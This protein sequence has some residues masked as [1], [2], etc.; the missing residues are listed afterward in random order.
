[1][2]KTS[3]FSPSQKLRA[4]D[5]QFRY[6]VG[7]GELFKRLN[8][9]TAPLGKE[10]KGGAIDKQLRFVVLIGEL[11]GPDDAL[12]HLRPIDRSPLSAEQQRVWTDLLYLYQQYALQR[13][14]TIS[15]PDQARLRLELGWAG[16]LALHPAGGPDQ[17]GR[18]AL[19]GGA[20]RTVTIV[21]IIFG[22]VL[23]F[24]LAGL[25][26]FVT[27]IFLAWFGKLPSRLAEPSGTSGLYAETFALWLV[28]FSGFGFAPALVPTDSLILRLVAA[29]LAFL[30]SLS[31]LAWPVLW[32]VPWQQV[33]EEIGLTFGTRPAFEVPLGGV[34]YVSA[35]P[36]MVIGLCV[37]F[38]LMHLQ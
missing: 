27:I 34:T 5:L 26:G 6:L 22:A 3:G 33:R 17:K 2:E 1:N 15:E 12:S 36:L 10:L 28:P 20:T 14:P 4:E 31:V 18:D 24:G 25:A 21:F 30:S 16:D 8:Q 35:L 7:A 37:T 13:F 32:G 23:L 9:D 11:K 19:L 29:M 38:L